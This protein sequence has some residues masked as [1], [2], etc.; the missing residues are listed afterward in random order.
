MFKILLLLL[1]LFGMRGYALESHHANYILSLYKSTPGSGIDEIDGKSS[2]ILRKNCNGWDTTDELS[3]VFKSIDNAKSTLSS[4][5]RTFETF[6]GNS[7]QF[8]LDEEI[9]QK[10]TNQFFGYVNS[11]KGLNTAKYFS[12]KEYSVPIAT[13]IEFPMMQLQNIILSAEANQKIYSSNVFMG[14]ELLDSYRVVTVII[15]KKKKYSKRNFQNK[16]FQSSYWP[17]SIAYFNPKLATDK[18]EYTIK[19][20]LQR[21][22]VITEY[23]IFYDEFSIILNLSSIEE[24][25]KKKCN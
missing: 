23:I 7:Y 18:P 21:N 8:D 12:D 6:S 2:Y 1:I 15:G 11:S 5:W 13:K 22:G 4:K 3:V 9:N 25:N 16:L 24:I 10:Q 19:A 14:S 17:V 20:K